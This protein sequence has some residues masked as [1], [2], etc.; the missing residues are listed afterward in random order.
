MIRTF[1]A[2]LL[3]A[4]MLSA[5]PEKPKPMPAPAP[6]VPAVPARIQGDMYA[7]ASCPV[8]GKKLG[9][10]GKP[11]Q[12]LYDAREVRFCC[13]A[14]PPRFEADLAKSVA[15]LDE[16]MIKDQM[17]HYP[18][19]V[20]LVDGTKL[21][22]GASVDFIYFNRLVRVHN[23]AAKA[24]FLKGPKPF[25]AKLDAAVV[26]KQ[27]AHYPLDHCPVSGDVYGGQM[28]DPVDVVVANR[29][30]RLCCKGCKEDLQENPAKFVAIVDEASTGKK[31]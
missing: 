26:A 2:V 28:G 17:P 20:C 30:I 25:L 16:Q 5:Q 14:C 23:E 13:D 22:G 24:E 7:L 11:V 19:D 15:K 18:L 29:L 21:E 9:A 12:K 8:S 31:K 4:L 1:A 6:T 10:M 3:P 27:G